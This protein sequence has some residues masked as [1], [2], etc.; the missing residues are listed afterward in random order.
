VFLKVNILITT[1][2]DAVGFYIRAIDA[3]FLEKKQ[4]G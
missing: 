2:I 1:T 3:A 4:V